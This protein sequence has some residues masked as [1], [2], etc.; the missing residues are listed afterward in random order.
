MVIVRKIVVANGIQQLRMLL[1]VSYHYQPDIEECLKI[2][3]L[4]LK[5]IFISEGLD[6]SICYSCNNYFRSDEI[7]IILGIMNIQQRMIIY[8]QV[9]LLR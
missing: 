4:C 9:D 3:I 5:F 6:R 2:L 8:K 7:K 1:Y